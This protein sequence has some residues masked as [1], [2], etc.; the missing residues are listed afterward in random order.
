[1]AD[2]QEVKDLIVFIAMFT[3]MINLMLLGY[4]LYK[5]NLF[6]KLDLA[7]RALQARYQSAVANTNIVSRNRRRAN[8][9]DMAVEAVGEV[10]VNSGASSLEC[11]VCYRSHGENKGD[12]IAMS[13]GHVVCSHCA[14][15]PTMKTRRECMFCKKDIRFVLRLY[16]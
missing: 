16:V 5:R 10:P 11:G 6:Q 9:R 1:M 4:Y 15:H 14:L 13:C 8:L 7:H 3:G 2:V 12:W